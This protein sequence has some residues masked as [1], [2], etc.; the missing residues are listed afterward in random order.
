M[1]GPK[2][3]NADIRHYLEQHQ[4]WYEENDSKFTV[5][6]TAPEDQPEDRDPLVGETAIIYS[7]NN[8]IHVEWKW[9]GYDEHWTF[10]TIDEFAEFYNRFLTL[11][12]DGV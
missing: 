12:I 7:D 1:T 11:G 3:T 5:N 6:A 10:D 4:F 2:L 9:C 8:Q